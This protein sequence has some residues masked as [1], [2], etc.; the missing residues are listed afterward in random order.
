[1]ICA[2]VAGILRVNLK[3][4]LQSSEF[5]A[6]VANEMIAKVCVTHWQFIHV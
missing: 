1:M 5:T 3:S 2:D 6:K 4:E